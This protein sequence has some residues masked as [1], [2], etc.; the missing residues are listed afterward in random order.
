M[1]PYIEHFWGPATK[2]ATFAISASKHG[3]QLVNEVF[4]CSEAIN[5]SSGYLKG[6]TI[7][8]MTAVILKPKIFSELVFKAV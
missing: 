8:K 2:L 7:F 4:I 1:T 6:W 3:G 5:L